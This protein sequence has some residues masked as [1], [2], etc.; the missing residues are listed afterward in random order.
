MKLE[1]TT[2]CLKK[3]RSVLAAEILQLKKIK[4]TLSND[5]ATLLFKSV[6]RK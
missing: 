4:A 1:K 2:F 5:V 3:K 6:I